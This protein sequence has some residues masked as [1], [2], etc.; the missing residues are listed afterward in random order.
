MKGT[1]DR[2]TERV[3]RMGRTWFVCVGSERATG[4]SDVDSLRV[5]VV[6]GGWTQQAAKMGHESNACNGQFS[7]SVLTH[8]H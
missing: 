1:G 3:E 5:I 4:L 7:Q 6:N 8:T 2:M